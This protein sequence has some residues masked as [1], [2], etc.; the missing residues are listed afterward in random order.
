LT[1]VNT[2][3][4]DS[5]DGLSIER[6]QPSTAFKPMPAYGVDSVVAPQAAHQIQDGYIKIGDILSSFKADELTGIN[7]L[8]DTTNFDPKILGPISGN[9][10]F[11]PQ[12]IN[13]RG[14]VIVMDNHFTT[15]GGG[16]SIT[17]EGRP[18]N[19]W[20]NG[21]ASTFNDHDRGATVYVDEDVDGFLKLGDI[22]GELQTTDLRSENRFVIERFASGSAVESFE[23]LAGMNSFQFNQSARNTADGF[24]SAGGGKSIVHPEFRLG[25]NSAPAG[26]TFITETFEPAVGM[27]SF[28]ESLNHVLE[29]S[30]TAGPG[31]TSFMTGKFDMPTDNIGGSADPGGDI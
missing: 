2:S 29:I 27:N 23:P 28:G 20:T 12:D 5:R 26:T 11:K 21:G 25:D 1:T 7:A 30:G 13:A 6:E 18:M 14:S 17:G 8:N 31:G 10:V 15:G 4:I 9:G 19:I 16:D 24:R 22:K 3:A